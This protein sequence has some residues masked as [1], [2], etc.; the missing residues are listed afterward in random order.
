MR[1]DKIRLICNLVLAVTVFVVWILSFFFW[2]DGTLGGSG[3][4]DLKYFTVESNLL[5]GIVAILWI[6]FRVIRGRGAV[7][8]WLT[9]L[10][11][12]SAAAVFVTFSVVV[13]F[14]GP[15]YGYGR[16]YYGSNLFFHLLI[17]LAAIAEFVF[18]E[19][20]SID[21]RAS[22]L[23]MIPPVLYGIGYLTNCLINGVGSWETVRNDWYSFLE[24]GYGV[25]A[26]I[27]VVICLVAWGLGL[28][29]RAL[30]KAARKIP[31]EKTQ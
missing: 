19:E 9:Y 23:A 26:L 10:K 31:W 12:L 20:G 22:F 1:K 3:W 27:F 15:M 30:N 11:Y 14:L 8:T 6:V 13:L 25:G 21:F 24:W 18:F 7:P 2:R 5:V 4:S 17:P 16:M 28:A 29:I